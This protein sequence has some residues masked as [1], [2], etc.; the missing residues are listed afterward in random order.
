MHRV[1][2]EEKE[3]V[4]GEGRERSWCGG[5]RRKGSGEGVTEAKDI[6]HRQT[7]RRHSA[8]RELCKPR[9]GA[10]VVQVVSVVPAPQASFGFQGLIRV[11]YG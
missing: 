11:D 6:H 8:N 1:S 4:E 2:G 9:R 3:V 5:G 10:W 7:S